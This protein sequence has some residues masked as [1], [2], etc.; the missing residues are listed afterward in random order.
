MG[1][2]EHL[3]NMAINQGNSGG[4]VV[5]TSGQVTGVIKVKY[6]S[7]YEG[8]ESD[9]SKLAAVSGGLQ[10]STGEHTVDVGSMIH[11]VILFAKES[12]QLVIGVGVPASVAAPWVISHLASIPLQY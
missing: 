5:T 1:A 4:P 12:S 6:I 10:L 2:N 9:L 3:L 7:A 11:Q 8:L